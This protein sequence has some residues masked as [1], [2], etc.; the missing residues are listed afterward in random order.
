ME[1]PI[2]LDAR[3]TQSCQ[4]ALFDSTLPVHKLFDAEQIPLARLV[5]GKK[6][7]CDSRYHFGLAARSPTGRVR[8]RELFER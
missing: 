7:S 6:S 1:V 2:F 4:T 3:D 8:C 5:H